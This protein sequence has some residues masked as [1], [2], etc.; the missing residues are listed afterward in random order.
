MKIQQLKYLVEIS[1]QGSI[2]K[3]AKSLYVTQPSITK[4]IKELEEEL[5]IE[6]FSRNNKKNLTFTPSGMELLWQAKEIVEKVEKVENSFK[7]KANYVT[8]SVSSQHYAFAVKA[9]IEFSNRYKD[10]IYSLRMREKKTEQIIEDVYLHQSDVG[11]I[12][13]SNSIKTFMYRYLQSKNLEFH[14]LKEV[15]F[16]A[17]LRKGHHLMQQKSV[18]LKELEPYPFVFYEQDNEALHFS[19]EA[20]AVK[21]HQRISVL[22]RGTINN[23]I[24]YTDG[25][26]I[27]SGF[28]IENI[29]GEGISSVPISDV[30]DV[31]TLGWLKLKNV[32]LSDEAKEFIDLCNA[33]I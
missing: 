33:I 24:C 27:G 9:F 18:T 21:S 10:S 23:V 29:I 8:L 13:I 5:E 15:G 1:K 26:T 31:M 16:H 6:I 20:V 11:I 25:Y 14:P 22:D 17:F 2:N 30:E 3:A 7:E 4:S 28:V 19:E 32:E 12:F